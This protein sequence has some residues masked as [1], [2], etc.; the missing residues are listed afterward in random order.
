MFFAWTTYLPKVIMAIIFQIEFSKFFP[1]IQKKKTGS[2][3][4]N[5]LA[6]Y[7]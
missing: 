6:L 7:S 4:T 3:K 1:Q 5:K 2:K